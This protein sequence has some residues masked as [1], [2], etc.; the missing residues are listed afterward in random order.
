MDQLLT[1]IK[2]SSINVDE[3]NNKLNALK[4]VVKTNKKELLKHFKIDLDA[5]K[6]EIQKQLDNRKEPVQT[7]VREYFNVKFDAL[8][9]QSFNHYVLKEEVQ[10]SAEREMAD[11]YQAFLPQL[12]EAKSVRGLS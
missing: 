9:D 12:L 7:S 2:N 11:L 6:A 8:A 5:V 10:I 1:E 3:Y 4:E